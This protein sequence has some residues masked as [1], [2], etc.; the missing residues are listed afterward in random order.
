MGEKPEQIEQH[1]EETRRDLAA[2]LHD[3]EY[4]VKRETDWRVHYRRHTF[5][6]LLAAFGGGL[7]LAAITIPPRGDAFAR[8]KR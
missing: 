8:W 3:L 6:T 1:I 7:A 2:K 4:R 5:A